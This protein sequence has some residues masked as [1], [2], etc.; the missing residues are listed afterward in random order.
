MGVL[1][2]GFAVTAPEITDDTGW[3]DGVCGAVVSHTLVCS[4]AW[5]CVSKVAASRRGPCA[6]GGGERSARSRLT[7]ALH[8]RVE[9]VDVKH[10]A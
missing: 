9:Y 4:K 6:P 2:Y 1:F 8:E 10:D 3:S 5:L 7:A